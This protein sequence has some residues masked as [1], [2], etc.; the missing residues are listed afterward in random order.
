MTDTDD[1]PGG[2]RPIRVTSGPTRM[3]RL[4]GDPEPP[5]A[6]GRTSAPVVL[7]LSA[8][9]ALLTLTGEIRILAG[10]TAILGT[11]ARAATTSSGRFPELVFRPP[12]AARSDDSGAALAEDRRDTPPS[13]EAAS[14]ADPR[15]GDDSSMVAPDAGG[16]DAPTMRVVGTRPIETAPDVRDTSGAGVEPA[17]EASPDGRVRE[18]T[19]PGGRVRE[20]TSETADL[21]EGGARGPPTA[22]TVPEFTQA[23]DT[24]EPRAADR[25]E[26]TTPPEFTHVS[27]PWVSADDT[28]DATPVRD[29]GSTAPADRQGATERA[30]TGSGSDGSAVDRRPAA[31]R[32]PER[33]APTE[34]AQSRATFPASVSPPEETGPRVLPERS[35]TAWMGSD[36][37]A[38]R[39]RPGRERTEDGAV[40]GRDSPIDLGNGGG[41]AVSRR[42]PLTVVR[43]LAKRPYGKPADERAEAGV[44]DGASRPDRA[45]EELSTPPAWAP[46]GSR[47]VDAGATGHSPFTLV[48][49]SPVRR[50]GDETASRPDSRRSH[51]TQPTDAHGPA[52]SRE[53]EET[54]ASAGPSEDAVDGSPAPPDRGR[55]PAPT[56]APF[57]STRIRRFA[58]PGGVEEPG[59]G[60]RVPLVVRRRRRGDRTEGARGHDAGAA[61]VDTATDA[62]GGKPPGDV[63]GTD[64]GTGAAIGPTD[65]RTEAATAV[66]RLATTAADAAPGGK[67][68]IDAGTASSRDMPSLTLSAMG[69]GTGGVGRHGTGGAGGSADPGVG[70]DRGSVD[71]PDVAAASPADA[72]TSDRD[73]PR[74]GSPRGPT[75][76]ATRPP[77]QEDTPPS[78]RDA[79]RTYPEFTF[80][81]LA[82]RIDV[83]RREDPDRRDV[84]YRESGG[85]RSERTTQDADLAGLLAGGDPTS[86]KYPSDVGRLVEKLHREM[87]RKRRMDRERRGL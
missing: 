28:T 8:P 1:T 42:V 77:E 34:T 47:P 51:Q 46:A 19:Q 78:G 40:S 2:L 12:M 3:T 27:P 43:R 38:D 15:P 39:G 60:G 81:T 11:V 24:S 66:H 36:P 87:E 84:T 69:G 5:D 16:R 23:S 30:R 9:T 4:T 71:S 31:G 18:P 61:R 56:G 53:A 13:V 45:A 75:R 17:G 74:P 85:D 76:D 83:T 21:S 7:D 29:E 54:A 63:G 41:P 37:S 44:P 80:K 35:E 50:S 26:R 49:R 14:R 70:T 55:S 52:P 57:A 48:E 64:L 22:P 58:D 65:A 67:P 20:D 62:G 59:H 68:L 73:D 32:A 25:P 72:A 82:P 33:P 86:S 6:S 79:S 10:R